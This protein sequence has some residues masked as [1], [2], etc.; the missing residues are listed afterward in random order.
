MGS[1]R[2]LHFDSVAVAK[3]SFDVLTIGLYFHVVV[4]HKA[5]L[6][7][8]FQ[9]SS[10]DFFDRRLCRRIHH[11]LILVVFRTRLVFRRFRSFFN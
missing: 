11:F 4:L 6:Q 7:H 2:R 1:D 9:G 5:G 3:Q 8:L 10:I